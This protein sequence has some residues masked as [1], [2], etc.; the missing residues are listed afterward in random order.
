MIEDAE[1]VQVGYDEC[2][3]EWLEVIQDADYVC[4]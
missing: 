3:D 4:R 2:V 1:C